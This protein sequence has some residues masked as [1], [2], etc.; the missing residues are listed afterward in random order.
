MARVLKGSA[1]IASAAVLVGALSLL[2]RL[3]GFVRGRV[4]IDLFD[5]PTL[6]IYFQAFRLPD[7]AFQLLVV[8]ALSAS[9]IPIFAK[10]WYADHPERA[11]RYANGLLAVVLLGF[12]VLAIV[13][14]V[15]APWLSPLIAPGFSPEQLATLTMMTRVILCGQVFFALSFV[16]G[17][18]LQGAKRFFL[19]SLAPIVYN[20]GILFGA[21]ALEPIWGLAGLAWGVVFGAAL[22]ALVQLVG[23][24]ALGYRVH[25]VAGWRDA[26]VRTTLRQAVPRMLGLAAS[27]CN[28]VVMTALASQLRPGAVRDFSLAVDLNFLAVGT[29]AIS[30][31]VAAYP[32]FAERAAAQDVLGIRAAFSLALR[33][34]LLFLALATM[35]AIV[36]RVEMVR[37]V[38]GADGLSWESTFATADAFALLS[39]SFFAQGAV[40]LFVRVWYALEKTAV[41]VACALLSVAINIAAALLL[42]PSLGIAGLAAATSIAAMVQVALLGVLT[43]RLLHGLDGRRILRAIATFSCAGLICAF[44]ALVVKQWFSAMIPLTTFVAVVGE[45]A[46]VGV[47]GTLVFFGIA[48]LLRSPEVLSVLSGLRLRF[49]RQAR[50]AG[51]SEA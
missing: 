39:M 11:Y 31:A 24:I 48:L 29:I 17:S 40:A 23:V 34:M 14:A 42:T 4:L 41:P 12:L 36:L 21:V 35:F 22:H 1:T 2:S 6:D 38:F 32:T 15:A 37:A 19:P 9:F 49:F 46:V 20:A 3:A 5:A 28:L 16:F 18:V 8:G 45:I 44:V 51:I 30:Y 43:H 50:P 33:Q 13:L 27:Q 47:A 10:Y 7:L 26:D 25:L